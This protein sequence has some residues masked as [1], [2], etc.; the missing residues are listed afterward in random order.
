MVFKVYDPVDQ[1]QT[2]GQVEYKYDVLRNEKGE[3]IGPPGYYPVVTYI[4]QNSANE[5]IESYKPVQKPALLQ[6]LY[7]KAYQSAVQYNISTMP[8]GI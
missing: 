1:S 7:D 2:I 8:T 4:K 5:I 3:K 6:T